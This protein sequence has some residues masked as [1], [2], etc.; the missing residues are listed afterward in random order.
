MENAKKNTFFSKNV[1]FGLFIGLGNI[2]ATYVFYKAGK[3]ITLN[4]QLIDVIML[5]TIAGTFIGVRKYRE[6]SLDGIISYGEALAAA[7][8]MI[9]VSACIY[10]I[11][12]YGLYH[13][14]PELQEYYAS[15]VNQ[16]L[17]EVYKGSPLLSD[18]TALMEQLMTPGVIAFSEAF[19]KLFMGF[20]FALPLAGILRRKRN[21][22]AN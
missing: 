2:L 4:R 19:N 1:A 9:A 3:E 22:T 8:L 5:L 12:I 20:I 16:L 18:M 15:S 11:F 13:S 17:E 6:E 10:G 7:T 21:H 14:V